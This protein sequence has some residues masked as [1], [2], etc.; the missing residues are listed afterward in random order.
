MS[1]ER[2]GSGRWPTA[3]VWGRLLALLVMGLA[4]ATSWAQTGVAPA[5]R[6]PDEAIDVALDAIEGPVLQRLAVPPGV[7]R[8]ILPFPPYKQEPPAAQRDFRTL[9]APS[10]VPPPTPGTGPGGPTGAGSG[11]PGSAPP[12]GPTGAGSGG[13]G[14]PPPPG[15]PNAPNS[16][17]NPGFSPPN[18]DPTPP[19]VLPPPQFPLRPAR[20]R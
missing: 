14:S 12:G 16:P 8:G 5:G 18:I 15:G 19:N 6:S 11:K 20:A 10:S 2:R 1:T 17:N 4:G 3:A 13:P 9:T 7:P